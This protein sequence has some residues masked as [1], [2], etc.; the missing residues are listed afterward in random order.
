MNHQQQGWQVVH[1]LVHHQLGHLPQERHRLE[2]VHLELAEVLHLV[3][4][5][6]EEHPMVVAEHW[7]ERVAVNHAVEEHPFLK[8]LVVE[9]PI[10]VH[11]VVVQQLELELVCFGLEQLV[12]LVVLV[13]LVE[14]E[15]Q[16]AA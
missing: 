6:V 7:Q 11:L 4:Q 10:V 9:Q 3:V 15:Q 14:L 1:R 13:L 5:L 8:H 12:V 2:L 16:P